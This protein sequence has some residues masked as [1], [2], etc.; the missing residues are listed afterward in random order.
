[1]IGLTSS[2]GGEQER[3]GA[4]GARWPFFVLSL[5]AGRDA[6]AADTHVKPSAERPLD[7]TAKPRTGAA[8]RPANP[9]TPTGPGSRSEQKGPAL[10]EAPEGPAPRP[11]RRSPRRD[12][13]RIRA[14]RGDAV[15]LLSTFG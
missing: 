12:I 13:D 15:L 11:T 14:L 1:M 8:P 4:R 5:S 9:A 3:G 10:P 7:Q 2:W 6:R